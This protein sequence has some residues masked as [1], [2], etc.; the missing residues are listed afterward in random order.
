MARRARGDLLPRTLGDDV[1]AAFTAFGPEVDEPVRSLDDVEVVLDHHDR[2]AG[3]AQ[4]MHNAEEEL[5]VV[6]MQARGGLVEDVQGTPGIAL[7]ELER[8]LDALRF[9]AR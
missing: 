2:V 1:A 5:D 8:E 7:G 3:I 6:E 4:A 9:A